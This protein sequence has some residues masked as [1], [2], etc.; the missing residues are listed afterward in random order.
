MK[1]LKKRLIFLGCIFMLL[2]LAAACA[3]NA[4]EASDS[5]APADFGILSEIAGENGTTYANLFDV[6]LDNQYDDYWVEKCASIVGD[7][8][9]AESAAFLKSYISRDIYGQEAV[10][11]YDSPDKV[12]FDCWY[13]NGAKTFTFK[14]NTATIALDDGTEQT[15]TYEYMGQYKVGENET[16][17]YNGQEIDP[18]FDCD[19]Y[20]S[21]DDAGEFTYLLMRDD[22]MAATYHIEFRYGSD[23][24]QLLLYFKGPYAYWLSAGIDQAA[25]ETTIHNVIDLFVTENLPE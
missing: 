24:D 15:H 4:P 20:K 25:D 7:D 13:I 8:A 12:G 5:P 3:A 22:N 16:M 11:A 2:F 19:V 14:D 10:D 9:A 21:T 18:S 1:L 6:I 23:L 17:I